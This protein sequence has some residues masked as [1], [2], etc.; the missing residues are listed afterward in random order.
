[1]MKF[2][3]H[4]RIDQILQLEHPNSNQSWY[5]SFVA[6]AY[7]T[8]GHSIQPNALEAKR[9]RLSMHVVRLDLANVRGS[10]LHHLLWKTLDAHYIISTSSRNT[11]HQNVHC[12]VGASG[13]WNSHGVRDFFPLP[14]L[15]NAAGS[16]IYK[17]SLERR[18]YRKL[19]T[20]YNTAT[21]SKQ[22]SKHICRLTWKQKKPQRFCWHMGECWRQKPRETCGRSQDG[23]HPQKLQWYSK[24]QHMQ[25][26]G[27]FTWE[28]LFELQDRHRNVYLEAIFD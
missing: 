19:E 26:H 8:F 11:F 15:V 2:L 16:H 18:R 6:I 28:S 20:G 12:N 5:F 13:G 22:I 14:E 4:P 10:L 24:G 27:K 9:S 3:A 23:T 17:T 7:F 21:F 1:M 25:T